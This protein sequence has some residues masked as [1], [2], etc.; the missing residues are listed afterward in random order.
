MAAA[1][2]AAAAVTAVVHDG[3][4]G[5]A[6]TGLPG[7]PITT[8]IC[9]HSHCTT[10]AQPLHSHCTCSPHSTLHMLAAPIV[11]EHMPNRGGVCHHNGKLAQY[12][13]I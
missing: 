4:S 2:A 13:V 3:S 1:A 9:V 11:V 7:S 10:N 5:L 6:Y 12:A 8:P